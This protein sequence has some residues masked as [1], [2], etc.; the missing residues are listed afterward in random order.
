MSEYEVGQRIKARID[1]CSPADDYSPG[2]CWAQQGTT[3]IVTKTG[4]KYFP[5][6]VRRVDMPEDASF[7]VNFDEVCK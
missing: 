3:L 7:G 1:I 6:S 2:G 4:G 5:I